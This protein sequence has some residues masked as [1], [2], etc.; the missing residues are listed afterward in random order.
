MRVLVNQEM[1]SSTFPS[2]VVPRQPLEAKTEEAR[3]HSLS[4]LALA[5]QRRDQILDPSHNPRV[6]AEAILFPLIQWST[7]PKSQMT[8]FDNTRFS[9]EGETAPCRIIYHH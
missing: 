8:A 4:I 1:Y 9:L 2:V 3:H 6:K 5:R 7:K